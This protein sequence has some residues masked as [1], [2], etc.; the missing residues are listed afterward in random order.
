MPLGSPFSAIDLASGPC[1]LRSLAFYSSHEGCR[2][3]LYVHLPDVVAPRRRGSLVKTLTLMLA[4]SP[5]PDQATDV[6]PSSLCSAG[7][8]S[9]D[10][11]LG[12]CANQILAS[13]KDCEN[14]T[15]VKHAF[16]VLSGVPLLC[17]VPPC[18]AFH[19]YFVFHSRPW[20]YKGRFVSSF[21][22][23][24]LPVFFSC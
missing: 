8:V 22:L 7:R 23:L 18:S 2:E 12:W 17:Q 1:T 14:S 15:Y 5:T 3:A 4:T 21:N 16:S 13:G 19:K 20:E 24:I 6:V 9:E 11:S 10:I